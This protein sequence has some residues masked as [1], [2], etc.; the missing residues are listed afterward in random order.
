MSKKIRIF[1]HL[2]DKNI[3]QGIWFIL[4]VTCHITY[5][6]TLQQNNFKMQQEGKREH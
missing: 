5:T 2:I 3:L 1:I 4:V 6:C